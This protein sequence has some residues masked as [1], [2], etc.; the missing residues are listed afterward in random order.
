[1]GTLNV[2]ANDSNLFYGG[3]FFTSTAAGSPSRPATRCFGFFGELAFR[4]NAASATMQFYLA[5]SQVLKVY[6]DGD[7]T[8]PITTLTPSP[9]G[10]WGTYTP[11]SGQDEAQ[12]DWVIKQDVGN[13]S[14]WYIDA[15]TSGTFALT[16]TG[17]GTPTISL[18]TGVGPTYLL[19]NSAVQQYVLQDAWDTPGPVS[20]YTLIETPNVMAAMH[21]NAQCSEIKIWTY[22]GS[23]HSLMLEVDGV[24]K[25][26]VTLDGSGKWKWV[27]LAAGLDSGAIHEYSIWVTNTGTGGASKQFPYALMTVGGTISTTPPTFD[28]SMWFAGNSIMVGTNGTGDGRNGMPYKLYRIWRDDFNTNVRIK[29]YAVSGATLKQFGNG[30]TDPHGAY[31]V[32]AQIAHIASFNDPF[33]MIL[34]GTNDQGQ[35]AGAET[36]ADLQAAY[37]STLNTALNG[38]TTT[39]FVDAILPK[40]SPPGDPTVQA[41]WNPAIV[42]AIA[43]CSVPGRCTY[44][45]MS[46]LLTLPTDYQDNTLHPNPAAMTRMANYL[47]PIINLAPVVTPS[48]PGAIVGSFGNVSIPLV[49]TAVRGATGYRIQ[50]NGVQIADIPSLNYTDSIPV[51]QPVTYTYTAYNA[52]GVS[53]PSAPL[54]L[55][56]NSVQTALQAGILRSSSYDSQGNLIFS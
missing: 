21:F 42:A 43:G 18:P 3:G 46:S 50:R 14:G 29:C 8:T 28:T 41:S 38:T 1:M 39:I 35:A 16:L 22:C 31:S 23:S 47:Y 7:F 25:P 10:N 6:R 17:T 9:A 48:V 12:H 34:A 19:A 24:E 5:T 56:S 4:S 40:G 13:S 44:V 55:T 11:F 53:P 20:G 37:I 30:A 51:G 32:Q 26:V 49:L 33:G 36:P 52:A 45:D 15:S 2:T 27:S 54:S